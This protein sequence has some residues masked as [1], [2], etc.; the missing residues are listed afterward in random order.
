MLLSASPLAWVVD[1][2]GWR[3]GF[4]IAAFL[5]CAIAM[6]V[7][8]CVPDDRPKAPKISA[9]LREMIEVVRL[10]AARSLRGIVAIA[11]VSI[12]VVLVLRGLWAGP[13]LM[14]VKGLSRLDAGNVLF[15]F[16]LALIGGPFLAGALDRRLGRRRE[17]VAA[18]HLLAAIMLLL[19]A[20][21]APHYAVANWFGVSQMPVQYDSVL[22]VVLGVVISSQPLIFAMA[23]QVVPV[24][25]TGKA[26]SAI[27]LSLFLGTAVMQSATDPIAARW[28]L[29]AVMLFMAGALAAGTLAFVYLTRPARARS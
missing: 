23:R 5:S 4:W 22:L 14:D 24:E 3:T 10:A 8:V 28:G 13:W 19:I 17:L 16:T 27:N 11:F 7:L 12:A 18:S 21:G 9:P 15:L 25:N 1:N 29:P 26:L 2:F 6:A 20:A